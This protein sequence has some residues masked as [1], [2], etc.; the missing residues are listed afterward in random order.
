MELK[1]G[2]FFFFFC[3]KFLWKVKKSERRL[4]NKKMEK[5]KAR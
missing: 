1:L 2:S 4:E 3:K 5:T